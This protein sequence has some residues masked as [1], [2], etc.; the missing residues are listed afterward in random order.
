M[1][2]FVRK[3]GWARFAGLALLIALLAVRI[4]DPV[5]IERL[6]LQA[7]DTYQ[8][9]N[10]RERLG[11][12]VAILDVDDR[13][14][15]EVGQWPWPRTQIA[16]M[17]LKAMQAGAV[18]VAFD[19]IFSEPDRLSPENI[20]L[21]NPDL[22]QSVRAELRKLPPNDEV[23]AQA[24]ARS[25]VVVGQTSMRNAGSGEAGGPAPL[26]VP[27][28]I[29]GPNPDRFLLRFPDLIQ[30]LEVLENAAAGHGMFTVLP[31]PDGVYRRVPVV[32]QAQGAY[33]LGLSIELLRIAT[34]GEAFA[35]RS[36]DAG[37]D[38]V[39]VAR[40]LI[41]TEQDGTVWNN[42]SPSSR[43]RFVSAVDL[44]NGTLPP[45]RLAGHLVLVGTS[46]IGLEDFRATPLGLPMAGVEIH[47]QVLENILGKSLLYRPNYAIGLELAFVAGMS[48][49][50]IIMA[51]MLTATWLLLVTGA[52][53]AISVGGAYYLYIDSLQLIDAT[54][55]VLSVFLA[56]L[57][58][59][60]INYIREEIQKREIRGAFGQ[61]VSPDLV[62]ALAKDPHQLKLGGE[63][64]ELSI[65][66]TDV[67]GFTTISES[68]KEDPT[69]LTALM[70]RFLT[71]MSD[72]IMDKNGTIDKYMGDAIMAFWNAPLNEVDHAR[73]SCAA[74]L[75]MMVDIDTL[76][77]VRLKETE[78]KAVP[79]DIGIGINT[80]DCVVG[81]MGSD[82]RFDYSALGDPVNLASRLEG[83]TK[84]Y[85]VD[86]IIGAS[87]A[88][89][90]EDE[91]AVIELDLIRVKGKL[92]PEHI[93]ALIGDESVRKTQ[94]FA[95]LKA[96]NEAMIETYRGQDWAAALTAAEQMRAAGRA[97]SVDLDFFAALYEERIA[98]FQFAPPPEEWDGV[99]VA[100][101]K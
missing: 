94:G 18:A 34:G 13:S 68:F 25:R 35:I 37:I 46:A 20:A 99:F 73:L 23:L 2:W 88:A 30:N 42:F 27:H 95:T 44:L 98:S 100:T 16:E 62:A 31:D 85:G 41:R 55:P 89:L 48:L 39:V 38:G 33:R 93:Y 71:I 76:N 29:L 15:A 80:G 53:I 1:R 24:F 83:Q 58:M 92:L 50:V 40:Q 78:G 56:A 47:A 84:S 14:L 67:R 36:N 52:L 17:T 82:K 28:A 3:V 91:F 9:I 101:S 79:I 22:P 51:P 10:P 45:G 70:N 11:A 12:P 64:R 21:D 75:Q 32:M 61:Y 63:R 90:V 7:F 96:A 19:V 86:I 60:S 54:F 6:R 49:L 26:D 81:N 57:L 8:Q 97:L 66:F 74:A 65:L 72:A 43:D 69:G 77:A 59:F 5:F 4:A 87:T